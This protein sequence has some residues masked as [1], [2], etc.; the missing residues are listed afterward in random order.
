VTSGCRARNDADSSH[1]ERVIVPTL[2]TIDWRFVLPS[3][4][5]SV[6]EHLIL[7]GGSDNECDAILETG[8]ARSVTRERNGRARGD[9]VVVRAKA[10]WSLHDAVEC[11]SPGGVLYF[12]VDRLSARGLARTTARLD[13]ELRRSGCTPT[14]VYWV[15]PRFDRPQ[16]YLPL[17]AHG[18]FAWYMRH[19]FVASTPAKRA[20]EVVFRAASRIGTRGIA[21]L[22][23]AL[24]VTARK[25]ASGDAAT[26]VLG[27]ADLP[28]VPAT[29]PMYPLVL[30]GGENDLNRVALLP[31]GVTSPR[32]HTVFKVGRRPEPLNTRIEHEQEVLRRIGADNAAMRQSVPS[33]LGTFRWRRLVVGN[34][35]CADGRLVGA[36]VDGWGVP[37]RRK[38]EYLHHVLA[39][40]SRFHADGE[41]GAPA[42]T[43]DR[44]HE[45]VSSPIATYASTLGVTDRE[46]RLF[47]AVQAHASTLIG[48]RLPSV[49]LHWGLTGRNIYRA[50]ERITIVD[51]EAGS[52]GPS[53]FDVL[54]FV[55]N[56]YFGV[57]N[58]R[59]L[60][61]R[62][63]GVARL[64]MA[65]DSSVATPVSIARA[66]I[67]NYNRT[68]GIDRRFVASMLA[69]MFVFRA[70]GQSTL[71][72]R[73]QRDRTS[74]RADNTYAAYLDVLA[75]HLDTLFAG[76]LY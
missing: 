36:T 41:L 63:A 70:L 40:V 23:P 54:Y 9:A 25:T 11:L 3:R 39:W 35:T 76:D 43:T 33:P 69:M 37:R 10:A 4:S 52:P 20:I 7:A 44:L 30:L 47:S 48:Q 5:D 72:T 12:E 65:R 56:W 61:T 26:P 31:F 8:L 71:V 57:E 29:E 58:C 73:D 6:F 66:A 24:A 64:F 49:W 38:I 45:W 13:R 50:E 21:A 15:F 17:D 62:V 18:A 67:A 22:V 14:G 60:E 42:W 51:W 32:P 19:V 2:R 46:H 53:L 74:G 16:I 75:Q 28:G 68:L 1:F 34:E 55:L 27:R 59:R